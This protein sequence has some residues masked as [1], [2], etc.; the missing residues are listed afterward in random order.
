MDGQTWASVSDYSSPLATF[1]KTSLTLEYGVGSERACS[2]PKTSPRMK[3]IFSCGK[4][5]GTPEKDD[6]RFPDENCM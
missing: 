3:I 4:T 1:T 2:R 6:Q 5:L